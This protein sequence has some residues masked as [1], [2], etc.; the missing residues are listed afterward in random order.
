VRADQL[1]FRYSEDLEERLREVEIE[2]CQEDLRQIHL[3]L[4]REQRFSKLHRNERQVIWR[5][6]RPLSANVNIRLSATPDKKHSRAM[7]VP[8][9]DWPKILADFA[10]AVLVDSKEAQGTVPPE[11]KAHVEE[12]TGIS[13]DDRG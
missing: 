4:A 10:K 13:Y 8:P 1:R 7:S 6:K 12:E 2:R 5:P 3:K 11:E 9:E